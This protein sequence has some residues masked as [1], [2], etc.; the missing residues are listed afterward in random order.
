MAAEPI[1]EVNRLKFFFKTRFLIILIFGIDHQELKV[2]KFYINDD[3]W[4]PLP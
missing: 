2:Y 1:N 3:H 4:L